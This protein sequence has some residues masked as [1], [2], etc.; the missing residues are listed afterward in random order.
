MNNRSEL[1]KF[2]IETFKNFL[3]NA[4]PQELVYNHPNIT[5]E[6]INLSQLLSYQYQLDFPELETI[7]SIAQLK[8][9]NT[10]TPLSE[11]KKNL[12]LIYQAL[13][14]NKQ[15]EKYYFTA[16]LVSVM[17]SPSHDH[18]QFEQYKAITLLVCAKLYALGD[19]ESAIKSVCNEIRQ[20]SLGK[21]ND[22]ANNLPYVADIE[23]KRLIDEL[24]SKRK[25]KFETN[26]S[27]RLGNQLSNIYV[28][29]NDSYYLN[30]GI[31]R[32][33]ALR[34]PGAPSTTLM[35]NPVEFEGQDTVTEL[36]EIQMHQEAWA[37]EEAASERKKKSFL[38]S[39]KQPSGNGYAIQKLQA[40]AIINQIQKND[41]RLACAINQATKF[42]IQTLLSYCMNPR[43]VSEKT[44]SFLLASLTLGSSF[45]RI[46]QLNFNSANNS[47][48][49][50]HTLPTQKQ[51][52]PIIK[53]ITP[54]K[55]TFFIELPY[56]ITSNLLNDLDDSTSKKISKLLN[57][58]NKTHGTS[59]TTTKI[60]SYLCFLLK[61]E[62]IDPT[63]IVLIKGETAKTAPEL[64]YTHLSDLDVQQTYY[65]FISNL[66]NLSSKSKKIQFKRQVNGKKESP[67]GSPLVMSDEV[68]SIFFKTLG[69]NISAISGSYSQQLHNLI[70]YYVLFTLA[71]SS[72]YRPVTGWLGKITDYNLLNL[73]LWISD[74]EMLQSETGRLIILPEIALRILKRYLQY[75]KAG[76]VDA[77]RLNLDISARYQQ[78][79]TG[80]QHLFFFIT[81]DVIEEVTP[82]T[83]A[84]HFD[85]VLPLPLNWHRHYVR[86]LLFKKKIHPELIAAWMGHAQLNE[87]AFTRFSS[88]SIGDLKIISDLIN[89]KLMSANCK[90]I[91]FV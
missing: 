50:E 52:K 41:M 28:P 36:I 27:S 12:T 39:M 19:H 81:D 18:Q 4:F 30:E 47:L 3:N 24:D 31:L 87:P 53:L 65:R 32:K 72:G 16:F 75:L 13:V 55:T 22:L 91:N 49:I 78:A 63:I 88:Y 1:L 70:T 45:E 6:I 83:M 9:S 44:R 33:K 84:A 35:I 42:E 62:S 2:E 73:T 76:A 69:I 10:Q 11:H 58:I 54:T 26:K 89:Q 59:L 82:S 37:S 21:R 77:S 80:E 7:V 5:N 86:S 79:I 66:E 61:Q 8:I 67:I 17:R 46:N 85:S 64:S 48:V 60:S 90:E 15:I 20:W 38:V 14:K 29:Y 25:E 57:F 40:Q 68:M 56:D 51:R 43:I 74:K 71:L 34:D 23:I